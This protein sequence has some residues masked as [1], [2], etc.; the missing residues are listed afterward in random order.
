MSTNN[1]CDLQHQ[2]E[3]KAKVYCE[4]GPRAQKSKSTLRESPGVEG[5]RSRQKMAGET[6]KRQPTGKITKTLI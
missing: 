1:L 2:R 4:Q 5:W 3:V 6:R